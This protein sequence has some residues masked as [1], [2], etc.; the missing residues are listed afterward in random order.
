MIY[1]AQEDF[2]NKN[3]QDYDVFTENDY[4]TSKVWNL[5]Y[6]NTYDMIYI[7]M[8]TIRYVE[9]KKL[10]QFRDVKKNGRV[11]NS[12]VFYNGQYQSENFIKTQTYLEKQLS[13]EEQIKID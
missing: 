10:V 6:D 4:I 9:G 1:D 11:N 12:E 13:K 8:A 5:T 3:Y 2:Y 7:F